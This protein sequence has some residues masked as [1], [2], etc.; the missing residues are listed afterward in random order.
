MAED[1]RAVNRALWD[2]RVPIH[3]D[4]GFYDATGFLAGASTLR[5]FEIDELGDVDGRTLVHA[6]VPFRA[7][8]AVVGAPR[9]ARDRA[10]LLRG[11]RSGPRRA[12]W[13]PPRSSTPTSWEADVYAAAEALGG[14]RFDAVYTGLGAL[15]WLPDVERWARVMASLVA[16][17]GRLYLAEFHPF[18]EVFADD[19]LT[20][21]HPYFDAGPHVGEEAGSYANPD[22]ATAH[23]RYVVFQHTLGSVVSAIAAAG[24]RI[25]FLHEHDHTLFA[26]WPFLEPQADT[27][28]PAA[29]GHA[30][31]AADVLAAR[32]RALARA[33]RGS[34]RGAPMLTIQPMPN[35]STHMPNSSPHI[36]FSSGTATCRLGQL[37][38]V[39]AQLVG[40]VAAEA[41]GDVVAGVVVHPGGVSAPINV[42]PL[43]VSSIPC[44][45][46]SAF[47]VPR[48]YSPN[49]FRSACRRT[50]SCRTPSPGGR[51]RGS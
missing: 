25:E 5:A 49:V 37:G 10:R 33:R 4:S 35:R 24:L 43:S 22:A 13:P 18:P 9:R 47:G 7:R 40:V 46:L 39:A 27:H 1:W 42:K 45:I 34:V 23:N 38:P 31:A 44:M 6:A 32:A 36:C 11:R 41:D 48:P 2:E 20:V 14:R 51:C 15:N 28:L 50:R 8:H 29:R 21:A 16:P 26:R 17:G 19:D 3:V 30:G 12:G